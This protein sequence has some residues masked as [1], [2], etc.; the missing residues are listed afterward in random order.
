MLAGSGGFGGFLELAH[1]W[2]D[3]GATKRS[4][5]L[6]A[7]YVVPHFRGAV[8]LREAR[9]DHARR[10]RAHVAGPAAAPDKSER[11]Q[12]QARKLKRRTA[13][14]TDVKEQESPRRYGWMANQK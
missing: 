4:Y 1:N 9:R 5:E 6:M 8:Q 12:Y 11:E 13:Q 3:W 10:N 14:G 2:A 7:R